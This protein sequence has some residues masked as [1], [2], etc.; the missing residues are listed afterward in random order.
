MRDVEQQIQKEIMRLQYIAQRSPELSATRVVRGTRKFSGQAKNNTRMAINRVDTSV[1][2]VPN[3]VRNAIADPDGQRARVFNRV[4][5]SIRLGDTINISNNLD[6]VESLEFEFGDL[7]F[8][9]A[10]ASWPV[11]VRQAV[12]EASRR[13]S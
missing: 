7:M 5:K 8:S 3:Y 9:R 11:D 1:K 10:V 13:F 12:S 2:L 4:S 6:Y